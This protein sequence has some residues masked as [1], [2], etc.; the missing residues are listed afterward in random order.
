[1]D[2]LLWETKKQKQGGFLRG[3]TTHKQLEAEQGTHSELWS[4]RISAALASGG[5]G[6]G[7]H[8]ASSRH[9]DPLRICPPVWWTVSKPTLIQNR[10]ILLCNFV[11][12][13]FT[14]YPF[15]LVR[16]IT[17]VLD[18]YLYIIS[19]IIILLLMYIMYI[20]TCNI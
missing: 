16:M 4:P 2:I 8:A 10:N 13:L 20:I 3:P 12:L 18:I 17:Q 6:Y 7:N 5:E 9:P 19:Y 15:S 1:M 14:T 11:V